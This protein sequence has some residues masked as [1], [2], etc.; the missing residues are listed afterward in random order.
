MYLVLDECCYSYV[1]IPRNE[2]FCVPNGEQVQ[3][4]CV[5][6]NPHD[7]FT[8]LTVT[9]F[10]GT[11][12]DM[13]VFDEILATSEEYDFSNSIS[14]SVVDSL[15]LINCSC[16]LYRDGFSLII[17]HFTPHKNGHYWC[18]LSINNTLV[19]PSYQAQFFVGDCNI[20][21]QP[22]YRLA[23][24]RLNENRCAKY[25]VATESDTG[26]TTTHELSGTSFV[27]SSTQSSTRLST[28]TQQEKELK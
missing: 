25:Y 10:R 12:E 11:T 24:L 1:S 3:I 13:S 19:Q 20:T 9:W 22:Y 5:I 15:S 21:N 6:I 23:N 4:N 14:G 16:D 26:L 8:N 27:A 2:T 7:N 18:Q 17:H 28:V